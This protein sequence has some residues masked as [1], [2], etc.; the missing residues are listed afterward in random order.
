MAWSKKGPFS[1]IFEFT[2]HNAMVETLKDWK[3]P[4][5]LDRIEKN[6]AWT[7]ATLVVP[8]KVPK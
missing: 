2:Y 6:D 8:F 5:L 7:G 3:R 1:Q 4:A